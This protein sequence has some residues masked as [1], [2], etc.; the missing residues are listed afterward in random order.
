MRKSENGAGAP[1]LSICRR[2][3]RGAASIFRSLALAVFVLT[4]LAAGALSQTNYEGKSISAI[5]IGLENND[6]SDAAVER[7]AAFFEPAAAAIDRQVASGGWRRR[8][9]EGKA[10]S[11]IRLAKASATYAGGADYIVWKINRHAGSNFVLKPWQ[12]RHPL[13]GAISLLPRLLKSGAIR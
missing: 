2:S 13:L 1:K 12:R 5:T 9:L 4:F 10:L 6:K 8:R 3:G 11:V 7:Y